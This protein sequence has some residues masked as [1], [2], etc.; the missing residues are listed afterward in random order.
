MNKLPL[1]ILT[2][3]CYIYINISYVV[4]K[5]HILILLVFN[6]LSL[7]APPSISGKNYSTSVH[8]ALNNSEHRFIHIALNN[9]ECR[10][11]NIALN[12]SE[13][14]FSHID[15]NNFEDRFIHMALNNSGHRFIHIALIILSTGSFTKL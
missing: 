12:N 9:S 10:F 5:K 6:F 14:R 1:N 7:V 8:I 3:K 4:C 15:L 2:H 13:H 11:I